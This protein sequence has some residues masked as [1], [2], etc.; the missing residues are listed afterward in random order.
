MGR[1]GPLAFVTGKDPPGGAIPREGYIMI[2]KKRLFPPPGGASMASVQATAI[3]RLSSLECEELAVPPLA[4]NMHQSVGIVQLITSNMASPSMNVS[5]SL[6]VPRLNA[7]HAQ[8]VFHSATL[9]GQKIDPCF[10]RVKV[11][12]QHLNAHARMRLVNLVKVGLCGHPAPRTIQKHWGN[13]YLKGLNADCCVHVF[14]EEFVAL[15]MEG[16]PCTIDA[17]LDVDPGF[18][19]PKYPQTKN[20][21]GPR[22]MNVLGRLQIAAEQ[23]SSMGRAE[24]NAL[25]VA[26][27]LIE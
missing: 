15:C 12:A 9:S 1:G 25:D 24:A 14:V 27:A 11:H 7:Q 18:R 5:Q 23:I 21:H 19:G 22:R 26:T 6:P 16:F 4:D 8:D 2:I 13:K 17:M 20:L 10:I 3:V